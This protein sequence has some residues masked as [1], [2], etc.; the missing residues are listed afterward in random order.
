M[1]NDLNELPLGAHT[2]LGNNIAHQAYLSCRLHA[3]NLSVR[4]VGDSA[5]VQ[6][7]NSEKG[8]S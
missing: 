7:G 3:G 1:E 4:E 8:F 6:E 2:L 5:K